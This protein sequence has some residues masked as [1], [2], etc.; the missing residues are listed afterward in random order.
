MLDLFSACHS[1]V[2]SFYSLIICCYLRNHCKTRNNYCFICLIFNGS[3]L[4][5]GL[6]LGF[7]LLVLSGTTAG[8]GAQSHGADFQLDL[9]TWSLIF[10]EMTTWASSPTAMFQDEDSR[11]HKSILKTKPRTHDIIS[12][13]RGSKQVTRPPL[14]WRVDKET[15]LLDGRNGNMYYYYKGSENS[16]TIVGNLP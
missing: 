4:R 13:F 6:S 8:V 16:F 5:A 1:N 15:P 9:F 7:L 14:I 12:S 2:L 10:K 3:A 11:R